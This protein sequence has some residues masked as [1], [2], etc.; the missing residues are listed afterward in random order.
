MK[1]PGTHSSE[2]LY[3]QLQSLE[4]NMQALLQELSPS[5]RLNYINGL[6]ARMYNSPRNPVAAPDKIRLVLAHR[7]G[8]ALSAEQQEKIRLLSDLTNQIYNLENGSKD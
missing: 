6:I 4:A 7:K 3:S 1:T 8:S 5:D 2:T